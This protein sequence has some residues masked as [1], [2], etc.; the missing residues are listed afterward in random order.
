MTVTYDIALTQ[1]QEAG[2][3]KPTVTCPRCHQVF[4]L[5]V[6]GLA[7]LPM[8]VFY[9][10]L[11]ERRRMLSSGGDCDHSSSQVNHNFNTSNFW[12]L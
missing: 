3:L 12:S 2:S 5:P 7:R 10:R 4:P 1:S 11:A 9:A 6:G 8:N